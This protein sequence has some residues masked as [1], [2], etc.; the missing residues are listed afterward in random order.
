MPV[1]FWPIRWKS[2]CVSWRLRM[3]WPSSDSRKKT[4]LLW[5]RERCLRWNN[6]HLTSEISYIFSFFLLTGKNL[7][8]CKMVNVPCLSLHLLFIYSSCSIVSQSWRHA[9]SPKKILRD[10]SKTHL[11]STNIFIIIY[12]NIIY[13]IYKNIYIYYICNINISLYMFI[14]V[15]S[16]IEISTMF[17]NCIIV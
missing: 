8:R 5:F 6:A 17:D 9:S 10:Y 15:S 1:K 14:H 12:M 11:P 16:V 4:F 7:T 3:D 13:I 2:I